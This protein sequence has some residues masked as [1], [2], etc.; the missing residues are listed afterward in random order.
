MYVY[1][2]TADET[3]ERTQIRCYG[4]DADGKTVALIISDFTPYVYIELPSTSDWKEVARLV[5]ADLANKAIIIRVLTKQHLYNSKKQGKFIF[6]QC[7]SRRHINTIS[8]M[9]KQNK[10]RGHSL[11]IHEEQATSVL[12]LVS[13]RQVPMATWMSYSGTVMDDDLRQTS[14]DIELDVS[15]KDIGPSPSHGSVQPKMLAFDLEVNSEVMNAMP[16]NKPLDII[17]QISCVFKQGESRRKILLTLEGTDLDSPLLDGIEVMAYECEEDLLLGF[18]ELVKKEK[19]HVI[20]GY[21]ILMFDITYLINR[22]ERYGMLDDLQMMGFNQVFPACQ[23]SIRW[24]SSAF[25]NQEYTFIDWEGILLLDL[26]PIIRRDYK[27]DNY[28]LDTVASNLIGSE[29]DPVDYKEIFAAFRTKKMARVGKYCVQDSNLCIDLAEHIHCWVSLSEMAVVCKVSMFALYTQGQQVKIYSQVYDY[30]LRKNIVVTSNGYE[31]KTNERYLGAYVM[32]PVPGHYENVIPLDFCLAGDG[33]VSLGNG[34]SKRIDSLITNHTVLAWDSDKKGL[35]LF[36]TYNGLQSKGEKETVCVTLQDGRKIIATPDHKFLLEDETWCEAQNLAGKRVKCG[37]EYCEDIVGD[38]EEDYEFNGWCMITQR[39]RILAFSRVLGYVLADGCICSEAYFGTKHDAMVFIE[40]LKLIA[41]DMKYRSITMRCRTT[42]KGTKYSVELPRCISR[43]FGNLDG[44]MIGKR[45]TQPLMLPSFLETCPKSVLREFI[46][47]LFGGAATAPVLSNGDFCGVTF[48]WDNCFKDSI[49]HVF[50]QLK[51]MLKKFGFDGTYHVSEVKKGSQFV[52]T[53]KRYKGKLAFARTS[54]DFLKQ[55]GIRYCINKSNKLSVAA[56]YGRLVPIDEFCD[57]ANR[58][59]GFRTNIDANAFV[60]EIG[61]KSWFDLHSY[62]VKTH[63]DVIPTLSYKVLSVAPNGKVPVYDISVSKAHCFLYSGIVTKNCSLYPSVIIAYNICYS[64]FV[65]ESE[66]KKLSPNQYNT[67]EWEDHLGCEHDPQIIEIA[68]VTKKIDALERRIADEV[69]AR[70]EAKGAEKKRIQERINKLREKQRP[71]RKTRVVLKKGK[72]TER[73]DAEGN[74]FSGVI[75]ANRK[76]RFL[77]KE[78]K[79][80]VIPT[81]I[82]NLLDSRKRVKQEMKTCSHAEKVVLDKKQLAY[83]VS[84]NSQYGAMG[85]RK[86]MLPFMPGAMCVT[87]LGR[88]A[89]QK[90]GELVCSKYNGQWIYTDTDSTYV[91]FPHL[92]TTQELWDYA[93]YVA[94][95]VSDEFPEDMTLEFEQAIYTKFV[96]LSKKRYMYL[97]ADR[98][99]NC[100]GKIG[101]RGVVLARRD[102]SKLLRTLYEQVISMTFAGCST[103]EI[104]MYII[105]HISDMFRG[106][107]PYDQYVA[108]KSIR[109]IEDGEQKVGNYKVKAL[110][111]DETERDKILDGRTDRQYYIDSCPAQVQLAERMRLRGFPV[112]VGS[113]ME[114]VVID[115]PGVSKLGTKLE[116]VNYF[117]KRK[118]WLNLDYL[119]YLKSLVNPLDQ[120]LTVTTGIDNFLDTQ[121][122]YRSCYSTVIAEIKKLGAPRFRRR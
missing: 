88:Q 108:T 110:P 83:K 100:D 81:I 107:I 4:I 12:Q 114:F 44:I 61:A 119:Y 102:N 27:F 30:C 38:D 25:K 87:Y 36:A 37:V 99:G 71:L 112:D 70:N 54:L 7:A 3:Q 9:I 22:C 48:A 90:A 51:N 16:C 97:S 85:V 13:L 96:I 120:L 41:G 33:L 56:S 11:T 31:C 24:S 20:T 84:A 46:A 49:D 116:D 115:K 53:N 105:E 93:V 57:Q 26:L 29:K 76:Y 1:S 40:D 43:I 121:Y 75:C 14:C 15:W 60:Q 23:K 67:F 58:E 21:N 66:A 42:S 68:A 39:D 2:W 18:I 74:T 17:F 28:K 59:I 10:Y 52:D 106:L 118:R 47:G 35:D 73:V 113:R 117:L 95:Q 8:F 94:K 6:C 32:D 45:E 63:D 91:L 111:A 109:S 62:T 82:Q 77:K 101:K 50:S 86:G 34:L 64:T 55:I 72:P 79:Q 92:T 65:V 78:I 103:N 69:S 5:E 19:P 98:D 104:E 122:A 80:G 89:I